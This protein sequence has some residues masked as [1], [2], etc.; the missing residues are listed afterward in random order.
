MMQRVIP[1]VSR[2]I[3]LR[4]LELSL[5]GWV[6]CR[7]GVSPAGLKKIATRNGRPTILQLRSFNPCAPDS[8][9]QWTQQ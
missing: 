6:H 9:A 7:A 5:Q 8:S 1:S 3:P 2:G 4:S